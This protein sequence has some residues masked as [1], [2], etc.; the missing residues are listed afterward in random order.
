[1]SINLLVLAGRGTQMTRVTRNY[2]EKTDIPFNKI[3]LIL[4]KK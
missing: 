3:K 1:M 2:S 4:G